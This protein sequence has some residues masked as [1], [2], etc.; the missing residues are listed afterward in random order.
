MYALPVL[1]GQYIASH[2]FD[3]PTHNSIGYNMYTNDVLAFITFYID[4]LVCEYYDCTDEA[5]CIQGYEVCDENP[6]WVGDTCVA[7]FHRNNGELE[8]DSKGCFLSGGAT[9]HDTCLLR[10]FPANIYSCLCNTTLCTS[11]T[12]LI[13]P[14]S[15]MHASPTDLPTGKQLSSVTK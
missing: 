12:T 4:Q 11:K 7:A 6:V 8:V 1:Y 15:Q 14:S 3:L 13:V 5:H 9:Y 10:E 2:P